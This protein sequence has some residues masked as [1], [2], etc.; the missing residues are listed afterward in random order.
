M[1]AN[2]WEKVKVGSPIAVY[3]DEFKCY[4]ACEV[5]KKKGSKF[6]LKYEND[7]TEWRALSKSEF[8]WQDDEPSTDDESSE[9]EN[10]EA[11]DDEDVPKRKKGVSKFIDDEAVEVNGDEEDD[12][13]E[14]EYE[15]I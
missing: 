7:D 15:E 12:G 13:E 6:Q 1:T 4:Y 9:E 14:T 5:L 8:R 10:E 3:W 11:S 2:K